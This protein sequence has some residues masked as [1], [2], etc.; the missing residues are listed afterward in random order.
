MI[1]DVEKQ[2]NER[3]LSLEAVDGLLLEISW[4]DEPELIRKLLAYKSMPKDYLPAAQMTVKEIKAEWK[5][6][7]LPDGTLRLVSYKGN[8]EIVII[9]ERIGDEIVSELGKQAFAVTRPH[10]K[11]ELRESCAHIKEVRMSD[12]VKVIGEGVFE[13]CENLEKVVLSKSIKVIPDTA[14]ADCKKLRAIDLHKGI[15]VIGRRSFYGCSSLEKI[16]IPEGVERFSNTTGKSDW[17]GRYFETFKNCATLKKVLLPESMWEINAGSFDG[18][19][20]LTDINI[21]SQLI[22]IGDLAFGECKRL[23]TLTIPPSVNDFDGFPPPFDDGFGYWGGA[24]LGCKKL[25]LHVTSGSFAEEYATK[26]KIPY[27]VD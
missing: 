5:T 11:K 1:K 10:I 22:K 9:P 15:S 19:S 6:E 21:P 25:K 7:D 3:T 27:V 14:F 16:E 12:S 23:S 24:F 8:D 13:G 17:R 20:S 26:A 2:I 18:C 4:L